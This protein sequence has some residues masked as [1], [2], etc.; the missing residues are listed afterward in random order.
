MRLTQGL[1]TALG[2]LEELRSS[3]LGPELYATAGMITARRA[4]DYN[5]ASHHME[6]AYSF[7]PESRTIRE[8]FIES[9]ISVSRLEEARDLFKDVEPADERET[10]R[11][12]GLAAIMA[13]WEI[14]ERLIA[15]WNHSDAAFGIQVL[16]ERARVSS[17]FQ[18]QEAEIPAYVLNMPQDARKLALS[19]VLH[20]QLGLSV[21]QHLGVDAAALAPVE[22]AGAAGHSRLNIGMGALGCALGHVSM[23][24]RFLGTTDSF[25]LMLEDDGLPYVQRDI[26]AL[27]DAAGDFDV[28]FVNNRMS[29]VKWGE[30]KQGFVSVWETLA[31]RPEQGGWGADGYIVSRAGAGKLAEAVEADKIIGHIDGQIASYGVDPM[32]E[33][34]SNAQR[35]GRS[36][37]SKS[38]SGVLLNI[39]CA[40]F[41]LVGTMDFGDSSIGRMG[42][43]FI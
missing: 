5:A 13:A 24:N 17:N 15:P 32:A 26:S 1:E 9:L 28:L 36:I 3:G 16:G 33:I 2:R 12:G 29:A 23:L 30:V 21:R 7:W 40:Q 37:H 4:N 35:I 31:K 11:F 42:G 22:R 19:T 6:K 18:G 8:F 20:G 39:K 10:V 27:V 38:V 41:P 14:V 34:V 43:H 25:A